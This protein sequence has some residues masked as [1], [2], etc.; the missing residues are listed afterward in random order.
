MEFLETLWRNIETTNFFGIPAFKPLLAFGILLLTII[1]QG[2]ISKTIVKY[3]KYLTVKAGYNLDDNLLELIKKPLTFLIFAVALRIIQTILARGA[4]DPNLS[5]LIFLT[6]VAFLLYNAAPLLAKILE[7]LTMQTE[8]E[9]DDLLV[10]YVPKLVRIGT[11]VVVIIKAS[12]VFLGASAGALIGLLGGAGVALGLLFK[13]IIYDWCCTIIIFTDGLYK[14]G[15][16]AVVS[17]EFVQVVEIGLRTTKL[18]SWEWGSI[19]K[20]PNSRMV[21][22]IVDNW[23]QD[24]SEIKEWGF[25]GAINID[26]ITSDQVEIMLKGMNQLFESI[27]GFYPG[28]YKC[29]FKGIQGNARV[30]SYMAKIDP[31]YYTSAINKFL[32]GLMKLMEKEGI[33]TQN[34]HFITDQD[35]YESNMKMASKN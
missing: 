35:T 26:C 4:L 25:K 34:I 16:W 12:E 18:Y 22:G 3:I 19:K 33:H 24:Q 7:F 14:P 9:L 20:M 15:D 13:D 8:T 31:N 21:S 1:F 11:V 2:I 5:S 17:G 29:K 28:K 6:L 23:S 32:L 10:P 27:D 30:L